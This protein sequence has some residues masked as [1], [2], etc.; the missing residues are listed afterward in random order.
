MGC[1]SCG[2]LCRR[3]QAA[4]RRSLGPCGSVFVSLVVIMLLLSS[5]CAA[6]F[7]D[8]SRDTRIH[9]WN[10]RRIYEQSS[11]QYGGSCW[12]IC[13][14]ANLLTLASHTVWECAG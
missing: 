9:C 6:V 7:G 14:A 2:L 12:A 1:E 5:W 10:R 11:M 3:Q 8:T 13:I 4:N